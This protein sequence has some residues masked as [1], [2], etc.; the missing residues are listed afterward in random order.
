MVNEEQLLKAYYNLE[1]YYTKKLH[2]TK[3]EHEKN[4]YLKKLSQLDVEI[5]DLETY[6]NKDITDKYIQIKTQRR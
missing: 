4:K 1:K 5:Y 3:H 6:L 2:E